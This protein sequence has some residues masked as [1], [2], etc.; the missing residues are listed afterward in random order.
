MRTR[1]SAATL[2]LFAA[3]TTL[4][5][6]WEQNTTANGPTARRS[7]AMAFVPGTGGLVLFGGFAGAGLS[8]QTWLYDGADW[9]LLAP[10]TS[11]TGRAEMELVYDLV[12]NRA[13]MYGGLATNISVPPPSNE[14]W[15][16]D[17]SSWLQ[18]TPATNPGPRYRH[19][20][21]FDSLRN[22]TV[23]YG[24]ATSQ[25]LGST[26]N[27]TWEYDGTNWTQ[28]T[29]AQNP[30]PLDRPA[31]CY[32]DGMARTVLFGGNQGSTLSD[33]TWLWDG[34]SWIQ[35]VVTGPKPSARI[36]A[37]M[38]YDP[39]RDVCV[40]M[41]G[42]D[43][44]G[45]LNDTWEFDGAFWTQQP[46]LPQAGRD[47]A[48]AFL[49]T[50]RQ[51]VRFGGFVAAPNSV[52]AETWEFGARWRAYGT[53][54]AGSLGV[55]ALTMPDAGRLGGAFTLD[56]ANAPLLAVLAL[57]LVQLTPPGFPLDGL[58][59]LGCSGYLIP[60]LLINVPTSGGIATWTWT[61]VSGVV[62]DRIFAQALSLDPG[63]NPAWLVGSNAVAATLGY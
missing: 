42:Q 54:C 2:V 60:D 18:A 20:L 31:M 13:V 58:G 9:T 22:R 62:G 47:H 29:P 45:V 57:G 30:G 41:G 34:T 4:T 53:G 16:F 32:A 17:G 26:T 33:Q 7:A 59:M 25:L 49:T 28:R 48:M 36:G 56:V 3:A 37:K 55:P 11:P 5:A 21:A 51:V 10:A 19:G 52:S 14:T 23:L 27:Q 1:L 38:V 24:G 39:V 46:T 12:R 40:L 6:Q 15:E 63:I 61:P 44:S 8:N 50:T 35:L 43:A